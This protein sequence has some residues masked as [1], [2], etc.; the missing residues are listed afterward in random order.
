M[1][2]IKLAQILEGRYPSP[3]CGMGKTMALHLLRRSGANFNFDEKETPLAEI[4]ESQDKIDKKIINNL[5]KLLVETE[6][7]RVGTQDKIYKYL[8]KEGF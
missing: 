6:V 7:F 8:L 4:L 5:L 3:L 2:Y 1:N